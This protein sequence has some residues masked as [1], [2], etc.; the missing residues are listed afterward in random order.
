M[1]QHNRFKFSL[2]HPFVESAP[3]AHP[4]LSAAAPPDNAGV[5]PRPAAPHGALDRLKASLARSPGAFRAHR[6]E[7]TTAV[8][9]RTTHGRSAGPETFVEARRPYA[10]IAGRA[11]KPAENAT[12]ELVAAATAGTESGAPANPAL[13]PSPLAH[14]LPLDALTSSDALLAYV[15]A[16][17]DCAP[18]LA[19]EIDDASALVSRLIRLTSRSNAN[20]ATRIATIARSGLIAQAMKQAGVTSI[21]QAHVALERLG[22]LDFDAP[23]TRHSGG[24]ADRQAWHIARVLSRSHPG[25]QALGDVRAALFEPFANDTARLAVRMILQSAEALDPLPGDADAAAQHDGAPG[26]VAIRTGRSRASLNATE[27]EPVTLAARAFD[28]AAT[29]LESGRDALT[30]DQK[31][32]FFAWRQSFDEDGR[33][34][35][36]SQARERLHKFSL[37]TLARV[38]E[39]RWKT[40]LPRMFRGTHSAPLAALSLGTQGVPRR[41]IAQERAAFEKGLRD[42]SAALRENPAMQPAAALTHV[43]A[44]RSLVELA[45]LLTWLEHGGFTSGRIDGETLVRVARRA[46]QMSVDAAGSKPGE[47][48]ARL[49]RIQRLTL[50]WSALSAEQLAKTRPFSAIAKRPFTVERLAVWGKVARMPDDATYWRSVDALRRLAQ[51]PTP[52]PADDLDEVRATLKEVVEGLQSGHRLRLS[53]GGRQGVST[54]G[55]NETTHVVLHGIGLPVSPRIDLRASRAREAVVEISRA[56]HGVE[57]FLGTTRTTLHHVGAGLLIGYDIEAGLTSVRAGLT[58]NVVLRAHERAEPRGVSLRVARRVKPDGSGYDDDAMRAKLS[59]IIDFLFDEA[60]EA[61]G[62][63]PAGIWNRLA[64]R[65]WD[66]LDVSV[67]WTDSRTSTT[68]QA[69]YVDASATVKFANLGGATAPDPVTGKTARQLTIRAGPSVGAAREKSRLTSEM[70]ERSGRIQIDQHRVGLGRLWHLRSGIAPGFSHPLD[71][72]GKNS[73]GLFSVDA[74]AATMTLGERNHSAKL[75]LV[76][77]DGLLSHRACMLDIEY[78]DARMYAR[79]VQVARTELIDLFAAQI[80]AQQRRAAAAGETATL[81]PDEIRRMAAERIDAHLSNALE[82]QRPNLTYLLRYRLHRSTAARLEANAA[83]LA[84]AG[85]DPDVRARIEADNAAILGTPESWMPIE[86]KIKER[87]TE[88]RGIGLNTIVQL[89]ARTS[90]TGDREIVTESVPFGV[91]EA[92]EARHEAEVPGTARTAWPA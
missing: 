24:A 26:A 41:T 29:L 74:P 35:D 75:Q 38:G 31:G 32:A 25:F 58:T 92:L 4:E 52:N 59:Q 81:E 11:K 86:L 2:F 43:R 73:V 22:M 34:S 42:A 3:D 62:D 36:L 18:A 17:F 49:A 65:Y 83:L 55:L 33:H 7:M 20:G 16:E 51:A 46:H 69:V 89:N 12:R 54:R 67:S 19:D 10:P 71:P 40:L 57:L 91:L 1:S 78:L 27:A 21:E 88:T 15:R 76:R 61:H 8:F 50:R 13:A 82:N 70:L 68:R 44:A 47:D 37:R 5:T 60:T 9:Q 28:A 23:Q 30:P 48:S 84:Q 56:T 53:D 79:A 87:S 39:K 14:V 72:N 6:F 45:A 90:A 64:E 63:G 77:E 85:G 66:D 80:V